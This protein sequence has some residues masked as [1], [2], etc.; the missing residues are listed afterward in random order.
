MV[1]VIMLMYVTY[2]L[3][4]AYESSG[5]E[6]DVFA[7]GEVTY[8]YSLSSSCPFWAKP[9]TSYQAFWFV[10]YFVMLKTVL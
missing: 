7:S 10:K 3:Y 9:W 6:L 5:I 2:K 1:C 8:L 4:M